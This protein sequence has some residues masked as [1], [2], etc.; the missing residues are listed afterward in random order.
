MKNLVAKSLPL[1]FALT[2]CSS[3]PP[4]ES[5]PQPTP[6]IEATVESAYQQGF[7]DGMNLIVFED[8]IGDSRAYENSRHSIDGE[9]VPTCSLGFL[10]V[11]RS[12][13]GD[14][15]RYE[16]K[17]IEL[18]DTEPQDILFFNYLVNEGQELDEIIE[19]TA[20]WIEQY[21]LRPMYERVEINGKPMFESNLEYLKSFIKYTNGPMV[22]T[23][24][25]FDDPDLTKYSCWIDF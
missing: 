20:F 5:T 11:S 22:K 17:H 23:P 6:N 3:Q 19:R 15:F 2:A 12:P 16:F 21:D 24:I 9:I 7:E 18:I 14:F 25:D 13:R 8:F 10:R 4:I 1:I